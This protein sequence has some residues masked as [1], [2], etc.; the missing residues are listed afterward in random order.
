MTN[1]NTDAIPTLTQ[2]NIPGS[3]LIV[4]Q[5]K[6]DFTETDEAVG[7]FAEDLSKRFN[8]AY[9]VVTEEQA[10]KI[11]PE[12]LGQPAFY[13]NKKAYL[14][15]GKVSRESAIHE[16]FGHPFLDIIEKENTAL[17]DNLATQATANKDVME[18]MQT[19]YPD[20]VNTNGT[21]TEEGTKEA[22]IRAIELDARKKLDDTKLKAAIKRFWNSIIKRLKSVFNISDFRPDMSIGELTN[23]IL[24][25]ASL[26]LSSAESISKL[27][28]KAATPQDR[29]YSKVI[30]M[31][32]MMSQVFKNGKEEYVNGN[33]PDDKYERATEFT[34]KFDF[35]SRSSDDIA[36]DVADNRFTKAGLNRT[37]KIKVGKEEFT[38]DEYVTKL[39]I[40]F[41]NVR[42][43]G[44]IGHLYMEKILGGSNAKI[45]AELDQLSTAI[46]GVRDAMEDHAK[47]FD[48]ILKDAEFI[49]NALGVEV[50]DKVITEQ[51]VYSNT[52]K[53][54]SRIDFLLFKAN[55]Q[56]VLGDF[57]FGN[58]FSDVDTRKYFKYATKDAQ[59]SMVN[60]KLNDAKLQVVLRA[61]MLKEQQPDLRFEDLFVAKIDRLSLVRGKETIQ[62]QDYLSMIESYYKNEDM[63]VYEILNEKGLFNAAN[64]WGK[65]SSLV[66]AT[67]DKLYK[68]N[69]NNYVKVLYEELLIIQN[70]IRR[71]EKDTKLTM[72]EIKQQKLKLEDKRERIMKQVLEM[73]TD[74]KAQE[75]FNV[76]EDMTMLTNWFGNQYDAKNK[77]AQAFFKLLNE[78]KNKARLK[79]EAN[80]IR[81]E[82]VAS[83][84]ASE[85]FSSRGIPNTKTLNSFFGMGFQYFKGD[86]S[87]IYDFAYKRK[88]GEHGEGYYLVTSDDI[89]EWDALTQAQKDYLT[90]VRESMNEAYQAATSKTVYRD[91]KGELV[92]KAALLSRPGKLRSDFFPRMPMQK[93]EYSERFGFNVGT[94]WKKFK[95]T[96]LEDYKEEYY[97]TSEQ[98]VGLPLKGM[99][100]V[101]SIKKIVAN[102]DHTFDL[103]SSYT[104]FMNNMFMMEELD[105]VQALGEGVQAWIKEQ[106]NMDGSLKMK[107]L[108]S[109]ME[110]Q[111]M[112]HITDTKPKVRYLT[113][114][115]TQDGKRYKV[116]IDS[117]IKGA[118]NFTTYGAMWL[119]AANAA[120]NGGLITTLLHKGAI[121]GDLSKRVMGIKDQDI[122]YTEEDLWWAKKEFLQMKMDIVTGRKE[123]NKLYRLLSHFNYMP[124]FYDYKIRA[125]EKIAGKNKLVDGSTL[126]FMNSF[127]EDFGTISVLASMLHHMKVKNK[128]GEEIRV[129]DAYELVSTKDKFG[130]EF[131]EIKW[132]D[133]IVRGV[134]VFQT[135]EGETYK[136][137]TELTSKEIMRLKRASQKIHGA[138]RQDER[139]GAELY[140]LGQLFL[141]FKKY[142]PGQMS[143]LW[144]SKYSD[145]NSG[146]Y[147]PRYENGQPVLVEIEDPV[148]KVKRMETAME[149]HARVHEGRVITF[150]KN[151]AAGLG[152]LG[153]DSALYKLF[154]AAGIKIE[155]T[156]EDYRWEN[157]SPEQKQNIAK[158]WVD[159]SFTLVAYLAYLAAFPDEDDKNT[160]MGRKM[161]RFVEDMMEGLNPVDLLRMA[162]NPTPAIT[163]AHNVVVALQDITVGLLTGDRQDNGNIPGQTQLEKN[164]PVFSSIYNYNKVMEESF[165]YN[166]LR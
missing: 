166:K 113:H 48:F 16:I 19:Y 24:S 118:K 150:F 109:F 144:S 73:D 126:M 139:S 72:S 93:D 6:S 35:E 43:Y 70:T 119:Q 13:I 66:D 91:K 165:N 117:L 65:S 40:E 88:M 163:R 148:T 42:T 149:W 103:E 142:L 111:M 94:R 136:N 63:K 131:K 22:I 145:A 5:Q 92:S 147:K 97:T 23:F 99:G 129:Y 36:T 3:S 110:K 138:Y 104:Q 157:L 45:D 106:Q 112:L 116:G 17:F 162:K 62:L 31:N 68:N 124:D 8:I 54:A 123:D 21:L 143:N 120:T 59:T 98:G 27:R 41:E 56:A 101:G 156:N 134:E 133:G 81:Y 38:F 164:I 105:D 58:L 14:V 127:V 30:E 10:R 64:Y 122:D 140:A 89:T 29:F 46:P 39:K 77:L 160:T 33:N 83:K 18:Y 76:T 25:D 71:L 153:Q 4:F 130:N 86:G 57:K 151:L 155:G 90:F 125:D 108:Y 141:Q 82:Q 51:I 75:M 121:V 28:L 2:L 1:N 20:A 128:N 15:K 159:L 55:G 44:K 26:D 79:I 12:Y 78:R 161:S 96:V 47:R 146:Y 115:F 11:S 158:F 60:S 114:S 85:Y 152:A 95:D 135:P 107:N 32:K 61:I 84:V 100:N 52:M 74:G 87:G 154:A 132:K 7:A 102:M 69:S 9:E 49:R 34:N 67:T 137:V 37:D 53:I 80:K 50:T